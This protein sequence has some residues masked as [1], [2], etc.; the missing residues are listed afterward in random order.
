MNDSNTYNKR[1][2]LII[3]PDERPKIYWDFFMTF[4]LIVSCTLTP[5]DLAF[6]KDNEQ[7]WSAM[8]IINFIMDLLFLVD[9]IVTF[10]SAYLIDGT[11][12]VD[13]PKKIAVNYISG[14]FVIDIVAIFPI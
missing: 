12:I 8:F 3:Y 10:F 4:V 14:W 1:K 9:I 6:S 2:K 11:E 13:K 5:V 7:G